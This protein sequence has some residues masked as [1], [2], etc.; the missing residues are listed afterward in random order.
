MTALPNG[1]LGSHNCIHCK[2]NKE[3]NANYAL[4][5]N[6]LSK[7]DD[8]IKRYWDTRQKIM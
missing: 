3:T 7:M 5:Y 8:L 4:K 1:I 2:K 6:I